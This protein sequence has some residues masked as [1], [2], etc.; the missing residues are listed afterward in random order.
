M[1][2]FTK[3]E[4]MR[5]IE[6]TPALRI[7]ID[8]LDHDH[9]MLLI[10]TGLLE[11][12]LELAGEGDRVCMIAHFLGRLTNLHFAR[13]ERLMAALGYDDLDAHVAE[14]RDFAR[15]RDSVMPG[16]EAPNGTSLSEGTIRYLSDWF[17]HH[18]REVDMRYKAYFLDREADVRKFLRTTQLASALAF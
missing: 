12:E 15:W 14:H 8:T 3:P 10:T 6:W 18:V 17:D 1:T 11:N 9:H 16:V 13:E 4:G 7:G 5:T 2:I